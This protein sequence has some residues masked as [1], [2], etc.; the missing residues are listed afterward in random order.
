MSKRPTG[1]YIVWINYGYDGWAPY[2]Y[3]TVED[4]LKHKASGDEWIL[5]RTVKLVE[6]DDVPE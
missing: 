2:D 6:S 1:P 5:T 4:A 3:E